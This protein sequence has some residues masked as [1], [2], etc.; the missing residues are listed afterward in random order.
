MSLKKFA[1]D[2]P[3]A[4][5]GVFLGL[6]KKLIPQK[7]VGQPS[8]PL[9]EDLERLA[10]SAPHVLAD[11]GFERDFEAFSPEKRVWRRGQLCVI[12]STAAPTVS[13]SLS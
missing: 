10:L 11:I 7:K 2:L 12:I 9:V 8:E 5:S 1:Q 13:V 4:Q 3:F 6:F